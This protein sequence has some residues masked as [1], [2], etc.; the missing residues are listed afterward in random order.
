MKQ[1]NPYKNTWILLA[2]IIMMILT[3]LSERD[4][5]RRSIL[6]PDVQKFSETLQLKEIQLDAYMDELES[7]LPEMDKEALFKTYAPSFPSLLQNDGL[8]LLVYNE[9]SLILWSDHTVDASMVYE[10]KEWLGPCLYLSNAWFLKRS[11][12]VDSFNIIG[13]IMLKHQYPYENKYLN[14]DF[15]QDFRLPRGTQIYPVPSPEGTQI[16]DSEGNFLFSLIFDRED[17]YKKPGQYTFT[18]I[19]FL[20]SLVLFLVYLRNVLV[21]FRKSAW[22]NLGIFL[23]LVLLAFFDYLV[24][25]RFKFPLSLRFM[26]LFS[27]AHFAASNWFAS[28]GDLLMTSIFVFYIAY[29]VNRDLRWKISGKFTGLQQWIARIIFGI[30][31]GVYYAAILILFR[32]LILNSSLSF[33]IYEIKDISHYTFIALFIIALH[34]ASLLL[35]FEKGLRIRGC[36]ESFWQSLVNSIIPVGGAIVPMIFT[37]DFLPGSIIFYLLMLVL[38][39]QV[40]RGFRTLSRFPPYILA[41]LIFAI[42]SV[43]EIHHFTIQKKHNRQ[44]VLAV[45]LSAEHD[46][47]AEMMLMEIEPEI[48]KDSIIR[49]Y[50]FQEI[51]DIESILQYTGRV[52]FSGFWEKYGLQVT[53]C[54]PEDMLYV[55]PPTD[56]MFP[57]FEYFDGL[58]K[59]KGVELP[60]SDFYF[61]D[62]L[63]GRFSYFAFFDYVNAD[64]SQLM[65]LFIELDSRWV[66]EELGYP[67]LLLEQGMGMEDFLEDFSY[68]KYHQGQLVATSGDYSYSFS[69]SVYGEG[70]EEFEWIKRGEYL[71]LVYHVDDENTILISK[72]RLKFSDILVNLSYVFIFYFLLLVLSLLLLRRPVLRPSLEKSFK[73]KFQYTLLGVLLVS[74]LLIGS[75]T[76]YFSLRQ[77]KQR[78][79]SSISEKIQSVYVELVHKLEFEEDLSQGW[80]SDTYS[81][82]DELLIKFSNVFYTDINIYDRQGSLLATSRQEIFDL[83]LIGRQ[84]APM[85]YLEM[86]IDKATKFIHQ[87][88]IGSLRYLSAYVPFFNRNN[89]LLAYL[90]L[91]YF[92]RQDV[93]ASELSSLVVGIVNFYVFL[94]IISLTLVVFLA[95]KV[96]QPLILIQD[97]IGAIKLGGPNEKIMYQADDEIGALVKEYNK[98]IDELALSAE[99]LAR[100]ERESAWREMAKQVAH[101]IK[102]PLT[103]MRLS[104]QHLNRALTAQPDNWEKILN[105]FSN[106]LIEQIDNLSAIATEFSNFAK[107]PRTK[108][109]V[110][111]ILE[112]LHPTVELFQSDSSAKIELK[113]PAGEYYPVYADKEQ[114]SRVFVNLIKNG[115]QSIPAE[116]EG[117]VSIE[118]TKENNF[119]Q[120][121]ISDNGKGIPEEMRDKLFQPNFTTK[122][123]GMGLGL[124]IVKSIVENAGGSIDFTTRLNQGSSF[125]VKLPLS[126]KFPTKQKK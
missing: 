91:P 124:A 81:S 28:L 121:T 72:P 14:N 104:V 89:K 57:C 73:N 122:S 125:I 62:N 48:R 123:G 67:G 16:Y 105:N 40:L 102:N 2:A 63:N 18:F 54:G 7:G 32:S 1:G 87:E 29:L 21:H 50:L 77:Y 96:T 20:F 6:S 43:Y 74:F 64:S 36:N 126:T 19:A 60:G 27:P 17:I 90:N 45:N 114:L 9:D 80:S 86:D 75:S 51:P 22:I 99:M 66:T 47:I 119:V 15:H 49:E 116:R 24:I 65:R 23:I 46:P 101:E 39:T 70:K 56:D 61:F 8:T 97:K 84:I 31:T 78:Q 98:M 12:R 109:Q 110:F 94:I 71:H 108:N 106:T 59:E 30:I 4:S 79:Y 118:V 52:Y 3:L 34:F 26:D 5:I 83:G 107:M 33:T 93:L 95:R 55:G 42:I 76:V 10:P 11:R 113:K 103:P 117:K 111:N 25:I 112:I 13:L 85:A 53:A 38:F 92:T 68:A 58:V 115:V 37:A 100:S 88:K 41:T 69:S 120:V 35:I 82:L 44:K